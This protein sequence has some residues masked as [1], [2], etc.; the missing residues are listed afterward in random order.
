MSPALGEM[1]KVMRSI[2]E[3]ISRNRHI[4]RTLPSGMQVYISPDSQ[5]KYLK[6]NFDLDLIQVAS[7]HV[8]SRSNVWDVGANCGVFGLSVPD[9]KELVFIEADPFLAHLLQMSCSINDLPMKVVPAAISDRNGLADFCIAKRGRA[10]NFLAEFKGRQ[11]A[12]GERGRIVIPTLT[13]DEMLNHFDPPNFVKI[14]VEGAEAAVL[15]GAPRLLTE[16]QPR[17][18][19]EVGTEA[20][21]ECRSIL[22]GVGYTMS[23][24][25]NWIAVPKLRN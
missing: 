24:E 11:Q 8:E 19:I 15:R 2:L 17:L 10:S 13:L 5:L 22:E 21:K 12:G 25:A 3:R 14:D 20:Q 1:R 7:N 4:L 9:A 18:Y 6:S 23:G 16:F